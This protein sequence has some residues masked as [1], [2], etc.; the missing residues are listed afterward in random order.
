MRSRTPRPLARRW[1]VLQS[2]DARQ[3]GQDG[4]E[5]PVIAVVVAVLNAQFAQP[6][7]AI[8]LVAKVQWAMG[9]VK[10]AHQKGAGFAMVW[11]VDDDD[12]YRGA[13]TTE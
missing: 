10:G 13:A 8:F 3:T 12:A 2:F 7:R 1:G 6:A 4:Q 5:R 9:L 11:T